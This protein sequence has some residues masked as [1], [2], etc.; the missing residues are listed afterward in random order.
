MEDILDPAEDSGEAEIVTPKSARLLDT[1]EF[2]EEILCEPDNTDSISDRPVA[3]GEFVEEIPCTTDDECERETYTSITAIPVGTGEF[4]NGNWV[5]TK[6]FKTGEDAAD[7]D[8]PEES[9]D[10][11]DYIPSDVSSYVS[12]SENSQTGNEED[13][14]AP[15]D[16]SVIAGPKKNE[17]SKQ[18][19]IVEHT[20]SP[21][22]DE[23]IPT[24]DSNVSDNENCQTDNEEDTSVLKDTSVGIT[25]QNKEIAKKRPIEEH[26]ESPF[27]DVEVYVRP[28][29]KEILYAKDKK[30]SS[31]VE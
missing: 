30:I 28:P 12:D 27:N 20:H 8:G 31:Y 22:G 5:L 16:T 19:P 6:I 1:R 3:T 29:K 9:N 14:A 7:T 13:F 24:D 25:P 17:R 4:I 18:R 21:F 10:D 11:I 2:V 23:C 15:K 26:T